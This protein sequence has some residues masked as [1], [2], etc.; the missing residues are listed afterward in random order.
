MKC[1][2]EKKIIIIKG[3]LA[4][5]VINWKVEAP[6]SHWYLLSSP[7]GDGR[8]DIFLVTLRDV[9]SCVCN[10]PPNTQKPKLPYHATIYYPAMISFTFSRRAPLVTHGSVLIFLNSL[11]SL[12]AA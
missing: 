3:I 8:S 2:T 4:T 10:P 7:R 5:K 11:P 12:L 1:K 9:Q 6:F